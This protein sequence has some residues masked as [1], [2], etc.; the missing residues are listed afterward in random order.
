LT[1]ASP[2]DNRANIARRVGS[3]KAENTALNVSFIAS[4]SEE[5]WADMVYLL[6]E[7]INVWVKYKTYEY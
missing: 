7:L 1:D 5:E 2:C 3:D 6:I 4:I